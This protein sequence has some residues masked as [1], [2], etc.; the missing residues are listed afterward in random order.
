[1]TR[2]HAHRGFWRHT[3][4]VCGTLFFGERCRIACDPCHRLERDKAHSKCLVCERRI[5][6][7]F[8]YCRACFHERRR[9]SDRAYKRLSAAHHASRVVVAP[10][11]EEGV[12]D[13]V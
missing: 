2:R 13:G 3:C 6:A 10:T 9:E 8:L 11:Y 7:R 4:V 5:R 12:L 1:M